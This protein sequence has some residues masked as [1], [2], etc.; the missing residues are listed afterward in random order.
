MA[1]KKEQRLSQLALEALKDLFI[2]NLL[3]DRRLLN[4]ADQP[5]LHPAMTLQTAL[6]LLFEEALK[7]R[8]EQV[9]AALEAGVRSNVDFFKRQCLEM[10]RKRATDCGVVRCGVVQCDFLRF[11]FI[12]YTLC[13]RLPRPAYLFLS[14]LFSDR[15]DAAEQAGAGVAHAG[16]AGGAHWRAVHGR[17]HQGR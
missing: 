7:P 2:N 10:V 13:C 11:Y 6:L 3:P 15:G 8:Y 16:P 14:F 1:N 9:L 4:F 5:L 12:Q 17:E